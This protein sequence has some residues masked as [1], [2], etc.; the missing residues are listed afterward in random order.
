MQTHTRSG[1]WIGGKSMSSILKGCTV[2][3]RLEV[4]QRRVT[5]ART[6]VDAAHTEYFAIRQADAPTLEAFVSALAPAERGVLTM[7]LEAGAL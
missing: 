7:L 2:P 5:R 1:P 3:G 4:S 6:E